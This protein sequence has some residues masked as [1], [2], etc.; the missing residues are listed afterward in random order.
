M[1]K[2]K[3]LHAPLIIEMVPKEEYE[4]VKEEH[5]R[6]IR[7]LLE[8]IEGLRERSEVT[9]RTQYLFMGATVILAII[10]LVSFMRR[11]R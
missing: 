11:R 10:A 2:D 7:E 5:E 6:R 9:E 3:T 4:A 8:E 1:D